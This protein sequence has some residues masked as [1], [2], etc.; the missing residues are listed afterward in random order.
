MAQREA[1]GM[2]LAHG[3]TPRDRESWEQLGEALPAAEITEPDDLGV[4]EIRLEAE[5]REDALTRVWDAVAAAGADGH[6]LLLE[7]PQLPAHWRRF[8]R[9]P[10]GPPHPAG[11]TAPRPLHPPPRRRPA[12]R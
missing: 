1:V 10:G 4:F 9:R 6:V 12:G 5:D 11:A 2:L 7:H 8:S 3:G